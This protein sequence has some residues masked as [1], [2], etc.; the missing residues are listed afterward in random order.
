[1]IEGFR[2]YA[3]AYLR[4]IDHPFGTDLSL[5]F[6]PTELE[7]TLNFGMYVLA[8]P[9]KEPR[10][11]DLDVRFES[12]AD[13][14]LVI[15]RDQ[16]GALTNVTERLAA[17]LEPYLKKLVYLCYPA[18]TFGQPPKPLWHWGMDQ[19]IR[20]IGLA[21][22]NLKNTDESYWRQQ[23]L[24]DANWRIALVSRHKGSHEAHPYDLVALERI[25]KAVF[26]CYL[27][28]A[29]KA[30]A[31]PASRS[32]NILAATRSQRLNELLTVRAQTHQITHDL[33]DVLE[34]LHFY[35]AKEHLS[36]TD[37][38]IQVLFES[39]L[40]GNG[41]IYYFLQSLPRPMQ[42]EWAQTYLAGTDT[43]K[44]FVA[45]EF[46]LWNGEELKLSEVMDLFREYSYRY[47]LAFCVR[48]LV[49]PNDLPLLWKLH[50][51]KASV[52]QEAAIEMFVRHVTE[53]QQ[54]FIDKAARSTSLATQE[55]FLRVGLA[56]ARLEKLQ[57]YRQTLSEKNAVN[58]RLALLGLGKVG[59]PADLTQI[60]QL[61]ETR[62]L[63]A[64]TR[65]LAIG[66]LALL[67]SRTSESTI[68]QRLLMDSQP[69]VVQ[70]ALTGLRFSEE[71][72][73][74]QEIIQLYTAF[75]DEA[76]HVLQR[77]VRG[78]DRS[79]LRQLLRNTKLDNPAKRIAVELCTIGNSSDIEFLLRRIAQ[80]KS[81]V[82]FWEQYELVFAMAKKAK[83]AKLRSLLL[84]F[85]KPQEFWTYYGKDR[86][87]EKMPVG[88]HENIPLVHRI[89]G[90]CF[91]E[92]AIRS[93]IPFLLRML[94]HTY[95]PVYHGAAN[96]LGR[97]GGVKELNVLVARA[98]ERRGDGKRIIGLLDAIA[99]L[100]RKIFGKSLHD[101][102]TEV[103]FGEIPDGI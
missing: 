31:D 44:K 30:L 72:F 76:G 73:P 37:E 43:T 32:R 103:C 89:V 20:E 88:N 28:G 52:V 58:L 71:R 100:D 15:S 3:R 54:D 25:A 69:D 50:R 95:W 79:T 33:P 85:I 22:A 82:E 7:E 56:R 36:L 86:P 13:Q 66:A 83:G 87:R 42:M 51:N 17:L 91:G 65:E 53:R 47:K 63:D 75:P 18:K 61:I 2:R 57:T 27:L 4:Q 21:S 102:P 46:L 93:D 59:A 77:C 94:E 98:I 6:S 34:H 62:R 99:V 101:L 39:H 24:E 55:L 96:A 8:A 14:Y 23:P 48:T 67:A 90:L 29:R 45:A 12:A 5:N 35:E 92:V 40:I 1:M 16:A 41:P 26:S 68:L 97:L 80:E 78:K 38:K 70:A 11:E 74:I 9:V 19:I 60:Q 84:R 10:L 81:R 64:R 49:A